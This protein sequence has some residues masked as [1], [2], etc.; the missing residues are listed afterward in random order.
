MY[1]FYSFEY[2]VR[3][4]GDLCGLLWL[5]FYCKSCGNYAGGGNG[6]LVGNVWR[7]DI[8]V[9]DFFDIGYVFFFFDS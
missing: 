9:F 4:V 2:V 3:N 8:L 5:V 6:S 1:V 7:K